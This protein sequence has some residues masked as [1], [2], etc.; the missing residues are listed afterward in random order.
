MIRKNYFSSDHL[1]GYL[2]C[3]PIG[4][5]VLVTGQVTYH[6]STLKTVVFA[7]S[8][9]GLV[10]ILLLK[11]FI[12]KETIQF[13]TNHL[14]SLIAYSLFIFL[15]GIWNIQR[16]EGGL[17]LSFVLAVVAF[18]LAAGS[19]LKTNRSLIGVLQLLVLLLIT[20]SIYGILEQLTIIRTTS[21]GN[22]PH[23]GII[24]TV[25]NPNYLGSVICLLLPAAYMLVTIEVAGK[26]SPHKNSK[27]RWPMVII[28]T[29]AIVV[30][31]TALYL[32]QSRAAILSAVVSFTI[33][34]VLIGIVTANNSSS[35][36]FNKRKALLLGI[37]GAV[38]VII[39]V[40]SV[41]QISSKTEYISTQLAPIAKESISGQTLLYNRLNPWKAAIKIWG[42]D[43]PLSPWFGR[44]P[45]SYYALVFSEFPSDFRLYFGDRS[46]KHA[47]NE[48]LNHL[49]EGGL[50]LLVLW[51]VYIFSALWLAVK[52]AKN[53]DIPMTNRII[54]I[55]SIA[56]IAAL[57]VQS[58]VSLIYRTTSTNILFHFWILITYYNYHLGSR[59]SAVDSNSVMSGAFCLITVQKKSRIIM[60][61]GFIAIT[62]L[63]PIYYLPS[64]FQSEK[65]LEQ[66][67]LLRASTDI[68][69]QKSRFDL[70][71]AAI[72]E[73]PN[74]IYAHYE[75][76]ETLR[77]VD[78]AATIAAIEE[79]ESVIAGYR[80]VALIKAIALI[81]LGRLEEAEY[82]LQRH[83][84]YDVA[85]ATAYFHLIAVEIL[86]HN[87]DSAL[88]EY[89]NLLYWQNLL[90]QS[91]KENYIDLPLMEIVFASGDTPTHASRDIAGN[92]E[93]IIS[94]KFMT[95]LLTALSLS[96]DMGYESIL[97]NL[98]MNTG[99]IFKGIEYSDVYLQ[100]YMMA[101][102]AGRLPKDDKA[103]MLNEISMFYDTI[104]ERINNALDRMSTAEAK[105]NYRILRKYTYFMMQLAYTPALR[106]QYLDL[107]EKLNSRK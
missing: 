79:I 37:A 68:D 56:A 67:L 7:A 50:V 80:D 90:F 107:T 42:S 6:L 98:Y 32:T 92:A 38:L 55:S 31:Y 51:L 75:K 77:R 35:S 78:P 103:I 100:F 101:A 49:A 10:S 1:M 12:R 61:V 60:F 52:T 3:L 45:G 97:I 93:G 86:Q 81:D 104:N 95:E 19:F 11:I 39:T 106:L 72:T 27:I 69:M 23:I 5:T 48:V 88:A 47:H 30:G 59:A 57:V 64:F 65:L 84:S 18:T 17:Y 105:Q 87:V 4:A 8:V 66:A 74:N 22:S 102:N 16:Y 28:A 25:G 63:F 46:F 89:Q 34:F 33:F 83:I 85:A 73:N 76:I 26:S 62:L 70:I 94:L 54:A 14:T 20:I 96:S 44:G 41:Q 58:Q 9:I 53:Q 2:V 82:E 15:P 99:R 24:S 43:M 91:E 21:P 29:L 36:R 40:L 71:N 13:E